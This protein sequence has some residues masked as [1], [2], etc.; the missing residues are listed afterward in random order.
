M[1]KIAFIGVPERENKK[2]KAENFPEFFYSNS[3][4]LE[5]FQ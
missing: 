5:E 4:L 1:S 3:P 2:I